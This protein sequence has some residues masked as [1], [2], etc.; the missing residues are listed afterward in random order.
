MACSMHHGR[1]TCS[2][3][4]RGV[5]RHFEEDRQGPLS[6]IRVLDLSRL[7]CGNILT[8]QLADFGADVIKVERVGEGDALRDWLVD[9]TDFY[10]K[11]YARNKR[12]VALNFDTPEARDILLRLAKTAHCLVE[13][14]RHGTLERWGLG[15]DTLLA[16]NPDL[17]V[18]R[19]S[20]WGQTGPYRTRPGFGTLVEGFSGLAEKT[21]FADKPPLLPNL[22]LADQVAGLQGAFAAMVAIR[23]SERG[24]GGQVVDLSLLEPLHSILGP[25]A[26]IH[27]AT[28]EMPKR[29][30]SASLT[31]APRNIYLCSDGSYVALSGAMQ[32]MAERLLMLIGGPSLRDDERFRT[33]GDRVRN[34]AAL[35]H[36]IQEWTCR[37][38][39]Q[40]ALAT[41]D[42][43]GITAGPVHTPA[44]FAEDEHVRQRGVLVRVPDRDL[45]EI[46][47]HD[48][49]P[50]LSGSPGGLRRPAP[51]VGEHS[52]EVFADIGVHD[53]EGARLAEN[54]GIGV[55][56]RAA[57]AQG[58][59][60]DGASAHSIQE[61]P[62]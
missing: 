6:G 30:G 15:P 33:N 1:S 55:A 25:D 2:T 34:M 24:G 17:V 32:T 57:G 9:G 44:S 8:L 12:S 37:H 5:I 40:E 13:S 28:G 54:G 26:A 10:W 61:S 22:P 35:D 51:R 23:H 49:S 62:L 41:F 11:V 21:G 47:M 53:E 39:L 45:G 58:K 3:G 19:V 16:C 20:G 36:L 14:F 29:T 56:D 38:T 48:V 46:V 4:A 52:G 42:R 60:G 50:R 31:S 27:A 7:V 43:E 59:G 18:V